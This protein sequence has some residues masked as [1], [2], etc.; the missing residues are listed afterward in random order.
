MDLANHQRKLLGLFRSTYQVCTEDG[1]YLNR[2]AESRDLEE[3]RRNI[4][5]WRLWVLERTS[6]LTFRLLRRRG[7]LQDAVNEFISGPNISPFR[8]TQAPAFLEA[9]S[10]HDDSL[11][12][13]V[14]SF[15]LAL[16]KVRDGDQATYVI[17]WPADPLIVLHALAQDSELPTA[18]RSGHFEVVVAHDL[19][20]QIL[21]RTLTEDCN[22]R[23]SAS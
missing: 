11:V 8:E 6:A 9:V 14:A 16:T 1:P 22:G 3:G 12:A 4:F 18:L 20:G 5:L 21:V 19:P 17:P 13:A 10:R 15:E 23:L 2:V 7:L